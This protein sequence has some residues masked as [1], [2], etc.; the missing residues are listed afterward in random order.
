MDPPPS[1]FNH[2]HV[3]AAACSPGTS[4]WYT[5]THQPPS[6][7]EL[8]PLLTR[9]QG[10]TGRQ[11]QNPPHG[12]PLARRSSRWES[13]QVP[14]TRWLGARKTLQPC[15]PQGHTHIHAHT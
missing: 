11:C 12:P 3:H 1:S 7:T 13:C 5:D 8:S 4:G 10:G 9:A 6:R 2:A 15:N 14:R